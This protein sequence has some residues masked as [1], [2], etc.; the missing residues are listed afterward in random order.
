MLT[1]TLKEL[2]EWSKK[3]FSTLPWRQ[4]RSAYS[5]LV[6][7]MMLQQTTVATVL[8]KF[9]LFMKKYPTLEVL[10][11]ASEEDVVICWKGLGYYSRAKNLRKAAILIIQDH[12]GKIPKDEKSLKNIPGIGDYTA[13][14]IL[15]LGYDQR[16]LA[17]DANLERVFCRILTSDLTKGAQLKKQLP[18]ILEDS[19]M[20]EAMK[21]YSFREINEALMDL[22]R[23]ICQA[24]SAL[25]EKC[26]FQ[27]VCLGYKSGSPLA[28][29]RTQQTREQ[30]FRLDLLRVIVKKRDKVLVRKRHPGEWLAG[31]WELPTFVI[32]CENS[33]FY[34]YPR[35]EKEISYKK[36]LEFKS[37]ITKY[38]INN[39]VK[40]MEPEQF[41]EIV[42]DRGEYQFIVLSEEETNFT[43]ATLKGLRMLL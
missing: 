8:K 39:Y 30:K 5:T 11:Q 33:N 43:T 6:S 29:P 16:C 14:A 19:P 38:K 28:Y 22:G 36:A 17:L 42:D 26:F 40:E 25:C 10:S 21:K 9:P 18:T 1:N 32:K 12:G 27:D 15:S 13:K 3:E 20:Y 31:Q 2:I 34:Q 41:Y 35:L 7:E 4:N 24:R 23:V 37:T